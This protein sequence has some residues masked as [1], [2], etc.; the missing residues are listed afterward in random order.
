MRHPHAARTTVALLALVCSVWLAGCATPVKPEGATLA[1]RDLDSLKADPQLAPVVPAALQDAELSVQA[2]ELPTTDLAAGHYAVYVAQRKVAIA[3]ADAER[4]LAQDRLKKL[5]LER[6]AIIEEGQRRE[7]EIAR[8]QA[9]AAAAAL[10]QQQQAA[11]AAQQEAAAA[12]AANA[13]MRRQLEAIEA[14][15]TDRGMVITLG[16]LL[17]ATGSA[18]LQATAHERLD[19]LAA[20]MSS[21]PDRTLL[22]EGHTDTQGSDEKNFELSQRRAEAVKV[23]LILQGINADRLTA[24]GRGSETPVADNVTTSGRQQNRR[25]E[26][27]ISNSRS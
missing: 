26:I 2:A 17:F 23:Y 27:V 11:A 25:V 16:D 12:Q 19:K 9:E 7:I 6:Q 18:A 10:A 15:S 5:E 14:K 13:E 21:Y 3:R 1:R 20:F 4:R 24:T 22:I 8:A